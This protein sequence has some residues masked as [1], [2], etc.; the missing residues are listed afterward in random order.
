MKKHIKGADEIV[1]DKLGSIIA[2]KVGTADRPRIMIAG[3]IDEIGFIVKE[4]TSEGYIK[5]LP[6]GGWWGHVALAQRVIVKTMKGDVPGIIGSKPPHILTDEE[7]KKVL[8]FKDMFIDVGVCKGFDVKALGIRPGDPIVP[9]SKFQVMG[10]PNLYMNKAFDNRLGAAAAVAVFNEFAK[11]KHPNTLYAVGTVQE[12]VGLRGAGTAAHIV[13][14]DVAFIADVSISGDSP[15]SQLTFG[16]LGSG[17]SITVF[18][19]SMIPNRKLRDLVV[20]VAE[21]CKIPYHFA[22]LERGGTDGGRIHIS[23]AGV[24]TLYVGAATRYIH[25]H[26]SILHKGDFQNLVKLLTEVI[27]RLDTKAVEKLSRK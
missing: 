9:D 5:F 4:I 22:A 12:E 16:K 27:K 15:D 26:T 18:D 23:R 13:D 19:G 3:H 7:R 10:N 6:L 8:D 14:P 24:P 17:P 20:N 25:S 2:K 1:F 21:E 11:I